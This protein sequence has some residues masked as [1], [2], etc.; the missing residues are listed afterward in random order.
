MADWVEEWDSQ[1]L[2][3]CETFCL[4]DQ[5]SKA[6]R[7][8]LRCHAALIED[9]L[10]DKYD[11][12]LTSRLQ[13][14]AL[15]HRYGQY[16]QMSGG[17]FLVS[18]KDVVLSDKIL[19]I[20]SLLKEGFDIDDD[21]K[22]LTEYTLEL[23]LFDQSAQVVI[24]KIDQLALST[25][26]KDVS[27]NVAGYIAKKLQKVCQNCCDHELFSDNENASAYL[28]VLSRGGLKV[29]SPQ[30][31][32]FVAKSFAVLDAFNSIIRKSGIPV[33][34]V[35]EHALDKF[36][37]SSDFDV[38]SCPIHQHD[39]YAKV[40]RK[41]AN[42]FFNNQRKRTTE[43]VVSDKVAVF[44]KTSVVNKTA[45]LEIFYVSYSET[46]S[47]NCMFTSYRSSQNFKLCPLIKY[48]FL[49]F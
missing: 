27:D 36:L 41:V 20:K 16:R 26:T 42:V 7:R 15:E 37:P 22:A 11:Y 30:R 39:L 33:R 40:R 21:V 35:G 32:S 4:S 24:D 25:E 29:A 14:D 5:T 13:S 18:L 45:Y 10:N 3:N 6:L 17:R 31:Q 49:K 2:P 43:N 34:K 48:I 12:V 8:T 46:Y 47:L 23:E 19:K 44:K 38:F 28:T 9:L 1:K